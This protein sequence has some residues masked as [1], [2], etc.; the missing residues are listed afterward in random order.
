MI[1]KKVPSRKLRVTRD[2]A[3]AFV[4]TPKY[5]VMLTSASDIAAAGPVR[6]IPAGTDL[7]VRS[8]FSFLGADAV[9]AEESEAGGEYM[10]LFLSWPD[11]RE[12]S[13]L[14][15][16]RSFV[17]G[18]DNFIALDSEAATALKWVS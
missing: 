5:V 17:A 16:N 13:N 18:A 4:R 6:F 7:V 1:I 11:V 15:V 10:R 8:V 14:F 12:A 9:P 2:N 3:V